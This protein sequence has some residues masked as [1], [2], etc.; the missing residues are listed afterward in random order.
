[1]DEFQEE[2]GDF[3]GTKESSCCSKNAPP[4]GQWNPVDLQLHGRLSRG[5]GF[6]PS[7]KVQ[8]RLGKKQQ[9]PY[10]IV[11]LS[12]SNS[13]ERFLRGDF[14]K[15]QEAGTRNEITGAKATIPAE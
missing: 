7:L 11:R 2:E 9:Q 12:V 5:F 6:I 8:T 15:M 13:G 14:D 1:M 3:V 10:Q 4:T